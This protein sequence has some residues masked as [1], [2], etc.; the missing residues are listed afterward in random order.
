ML[1]VYRFAPAW[2]VPCFSPFV[3][4]VIYYLRMAR[5]PHEI[6]AQDASR[7]AQDAPYGKLPYIVDE[8]KKIAD[9]TTIIDYLET[10]FGGRLDGDAKPAEKA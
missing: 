5:I 2:D 1:S 9:S 10:K 4:K 7:L 3:T 8:G 6:V